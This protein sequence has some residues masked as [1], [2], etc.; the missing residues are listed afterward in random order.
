MSWWKERDTKVGMMSE[1]D[2]KGEGSAKMGGGEDGP[3]CLTSRSG[4]GAVM[5]VGNFP[6][7]MSCRGDISDAAWRDGEAHCKREQTVQSRR[8]NLAQ[9]SI[10]EPCV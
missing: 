4:S 7:G 2:G 8:Y 9:G 1:V 3:F 6:P 10:A 5:Q